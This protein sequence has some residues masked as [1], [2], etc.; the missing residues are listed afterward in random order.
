MWHVKR[1]TKRSMQQTTGPALHN[2]YPLGQNLLTIQ[3]IEGAIIMYRLLRAD[4]VCPS[5]GGLWKWVIFTLSLHCQ[6]V[7]WTTQEGSLNCSEWNNFCLTA[8]YPACINFQSLCW[9]GYNVLTEMYVFKAWFY[10]QK[11]KNRPKGLFVGKK[12]SI[13]L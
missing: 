2:H 8:C 13:I 6:G 5:A 9:Y 7:A 11:V 1:W 3:L 4:T 10:S 12:K